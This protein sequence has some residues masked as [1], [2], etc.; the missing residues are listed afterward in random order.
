MWWG[1]GP[2]RRRALSG[3]L[4]VSPVVGGHGSSL[5]VDPF[6]G[7]KPRVAV[8]AEEDLPVALVDQFVVKTAEQ[9]EVRQCRLAAVRPVVD[10]V[11]VG[12]GGGAATPWGYPLHEVLGGGRCSRS[13]GRRGR[14]AGA[15]G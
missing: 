13:R 2:G 3:E 6:R 10:V 8:V 11:G 9:G 7:E 12:P 4:V 5:W 15:S 14:G 1:R